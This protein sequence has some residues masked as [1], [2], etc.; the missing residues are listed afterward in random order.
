MLHLRAARCASAASAAA[1]AA[2]RRGGGTARRAGA[3]AAPMGAGPAAPVLACNVYISEGRDAALLRD[4]EAAAGPGALLC[5]L[6]CSARELLRCVRWRAC[7]MACA[8][9][10]APCV[11]CVLVSE[12]VGAALLPA[13]VHVF[14]D[15]A[16][17][18]T[19]FTLASARPEAVRARA[20]PSLLRGAARR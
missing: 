12:C 19:G 16:Y 2:C 7:V 9:R 5:V 15:D 11:R 6:R 1:A 10:L 13:C 18:R 3:A 20:R 8:A 4:L 17:N 14:R